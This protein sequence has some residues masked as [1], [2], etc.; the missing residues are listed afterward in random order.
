MTWVKIC[1]ITNLEDA[2]VAVD[3]GADAVGFVFY[4]KSPRYISAEDAEKIVKALPAQIEKIGV[5]VGNPQ[6]FMYEIV[7]RVGLT[8]I[9]AHVDANVAAI[10]GLKSSSRVK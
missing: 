10:N 9:Q 4:E 8:G 3:A 2:Q 5:F 6:D 1:G 7:E